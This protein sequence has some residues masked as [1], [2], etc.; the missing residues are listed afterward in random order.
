MTKNKNQHYLS[1]FY[2]YNFT[3]NDQRYKS[4][5]KPCRET[6]IHHYDFSRKCLR[7]RPI[8]NLAIESYFFSY[9]NT[10]SSYNHSLDHQVQGVE[11]K[12]AN[13]IGQLNDILKYALKKNPRTVKIENSVIDDVMELLF[14]QIKRHPEIIKEL[15]SNC[16]QYLIYKGET[17]QAAKQMA[18]KV[19]EEMGSGGVYDIRNELQKKNKTIVCIS[20]NDAHFITTDK[21]FV[22]FNNAGRNGIAIPG[23]E[24]YFPITSNML[25]FMCNNGDRKEF[26]LERDRSFLRKLNTYIAKSASRYLF[27]PSKEYLKRI[28]Q[29][30]GQPCTEIENGADT[31]A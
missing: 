5:G 24:M 26:Q 4:K 12:A 13:A 30:I 31:L 25:L 2:L 19:I 3:N 29:N 27:G 11:N 18:L 1:A 9:K 8:K 6:K 21:P 10:D 15:E 20:R 14:W 7:E 16:E 17:T 28:V 23:T 22:R